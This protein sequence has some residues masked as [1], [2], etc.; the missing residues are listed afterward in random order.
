MEY[1]FSSIHVNDRKVSFS[2]IVSGGAV[3]ANAFEDSTFDFIRDWVT[4]RS[5]FFIQTSGSTGKP[6][7]I[8]ITREQMIASATATALALSLK[9]KDTALVCLDTRYIAGRMMLVR[10]FTTG[11]AIRAITPSANPLEY[12]QNGESIHFA[13]FVPY[14]LHTILRSEQSARF[15]H[16]DTVIV[17]GAPLSREDEDLLQPLKC[18]VFVTYGMTETISHIALRRV[19][20]EE[21]S[22]M[23]RALPGIGLELDSRSCLIVDCPYI[24]GKLPTNDIVNLVGKAT[25]EWLGRFDNVINS[26]G[27]KIHPEVLESALEPW[28]RELNLKGRFLVSALADAEWGEKVVLV[29]EEQSVDLKDKQ[30]ILNTLHSRLAKYHSPRE[31]LTQFP[32]PETSNGKVDRLE[33]KRRI[34]RGL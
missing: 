32:F 22:K 23:Y 10:C 3:A 33:L 31:I 4:G 21:R 19:N 28:I 29:L 24:S 6:K 15:A 2:Q 30:Q 1:P 20:G 9:S 34:N 5:E 16:I 12:V 27:V 17:G 18:R 14:Q 7:T 8:L 13:A 26:G 25:F 11:M